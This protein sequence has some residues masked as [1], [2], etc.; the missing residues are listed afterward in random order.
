[1]SEISLPTVE[2]INAI[3]TTALVWDDLI[4][5]PL[6][7]EVA[8]VIKTLTDQLDS[9]E[10]VSCRELYAGTGKTASFIKDNATNGLSLKI[11]TVD[12]FDD[13]FFATSD[14]FMNCT[15]HGNIYKL[16][17][18]GTR[19]IVYDDV[20]NPVSVNLTDPFNYDPP[21]TYRT[22]NLNEDP[23]PLKIE[24]LSQLDVVTVPLSCIKNVNNEALGSSS[25]KFKPS[26]VIYMT[27]PISIGSA[28]HEEDGLIREMSGVMK[29]LPVGGV[30][31]I[32]YIHLPK[33]NVA[34]WQ[35]YEANKHLGYEFEELFCNELNGVFS[36]AVIKRTA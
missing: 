36:V 31:M 35:A 21:N 1:M 19:E 12:M 29:N 20:G 24:E 33:T 26:L 34:F 18:A 32:T 3:D 16:D 25:E 11:V 7:P 6:T 23:V 13:T 30:L 4:D 5:G 14:Y 27:W 9:G 17:I 28:A 15:N 10:H 22:I 2:Q 8:A